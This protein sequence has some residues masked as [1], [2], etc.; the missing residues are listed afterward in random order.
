MYGISGFDKCS[1]VSTPP[2]QPANISPKRA[3]LDWT[4]GNN[5]PKFRPMFFFA[6][7][8]S[9]RWTIAFLSHEKKTLRNDDGG[10][11]V[12]SI[13]PLTNDADFDRASRAY[14]T[15]LICKLRS[16]VWM[17]AIRCNGRTWLILGRA[18][19]I[20]NCRFF[21]QI[22]CEP[23]LAKKKHKNIFYYSSL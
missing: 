7:Q 20:K 10:G 19:G 2:T 22:K 14:T 15:L 5:I 18:I 16:F 1:L 13:S 12:S 23:E 3:W 9:V 4:D 11:R 21:S 6:E 8:T 17:A